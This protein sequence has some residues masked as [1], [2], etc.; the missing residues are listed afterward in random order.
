M[1]GLLGLLLLLPLWIEVEG[2]IQVWTIKIN[3]PHNFK[4]EYAG[5][6]RGNQLHGERSMIFSAGK[7]H[8]SRPLT[9]P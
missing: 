8:H 2:D 7:S 1:L 4:I 5:G 6:G 3:L 9:H